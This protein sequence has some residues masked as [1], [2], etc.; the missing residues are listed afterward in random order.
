MNE[1]HYTDQMFIFFRS[2]CSDD[3]IAHCMRT[4]NLVPSERNIW[5]ITDYVIV[6]TDD[7][8][9]VDKLNLIWCFLN[10][11]GTIIYQGAAFER[12]RQTFLMTEL[13]KNQI[14]NQQ[15]EAEVLMPWIDCTNGEPYFVLNT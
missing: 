11:G 13:I 9:I 3:F 5:D 8:T 12:N 7:I 4:I 2:H 10:N 1:L 14:I 15:Q 6:D